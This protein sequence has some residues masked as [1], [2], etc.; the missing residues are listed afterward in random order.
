MSILGRDPLVLP[1]RAVKGAR[2]QAPQLEREAGPNL[3]Q[4]RLVALLLLREHVS[5]TIGKQGII[6]SLT[7]K[8]QGRASACDTGIQRASEC[9]TGMLNEDAS[10]KKDNTIKTNSEDEPSCITSK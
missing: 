6:L 2:L 5:A 1:A 4:A 3:L 10:L 7:H 9:D 8:F